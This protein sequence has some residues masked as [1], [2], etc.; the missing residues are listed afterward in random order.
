MHL[1]KW[2]LTQ[3]IHLIMLSGQMRVQYK[4]QVLKSAANHTVKIH[5]WAGILKRGDT[6]SV[7]S[8][9]MATISGF[10]SIILPRKYQAACSAYGG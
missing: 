3:A 8:P 6:T 7:Q 1:P 2:S 5:V 4:E 9:I 10:P